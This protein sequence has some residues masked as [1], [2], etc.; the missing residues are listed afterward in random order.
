MNH[1]VLD[2]LDNFIVFPV[3]HNPRKYVAILT[4]EMTLEVKGISI[5]YIKL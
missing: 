5:M 1:R 3:D 4:R 2:L